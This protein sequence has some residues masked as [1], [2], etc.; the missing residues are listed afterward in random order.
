MA[1]Q[2]KNPHSVKLNGAIVLIRINYINN[3][4]NIVFIFQLQSTS[5]LN[6]LKQAVYM[7]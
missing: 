4:I 1:S 3:T 7:V 6:Q 5:V 2:M